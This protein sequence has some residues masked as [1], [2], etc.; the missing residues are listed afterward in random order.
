[1]INWILIMTCLNIASYNC[2]GHAPDR[3]RYVKHLC[4]HNDFVMIQEHWYMEDQIQPELC[5]CINDVMVHGCSGMNS[6]AMLEGRPYGGCAILWK[7]SINIKIKHVEVESKRICAI[8]ISLPDRDVL[9]INTYMPCDSPVNEIAYQETM[10]QIE[11][12]CTMSNVDHIVIGGDFNTDLSRPHSLNTIM[13]NE[14]VQRESLQYCISLNL[15]QVD[16]TYESKATRNKSL[17]DHFIVSNNLSSRVES[18]K[19]IH[20]G[21]NLSDHSPIILG[22]AIPVDYTNNKTPQ[23]CKSKSLW[24]RST[25]VDK[26]YYKC[27][28]DD[29]LTKLSIPIDALC[30]PVYGCSNV[31]HQEGIQQ[32][33]DD[34]C[35]CLVN[36]SVQAIHQSSTS[37]KSVPGW[38]AIVEEHRERAL[39]WHQLWKDNNSPRVGLIADIRQKTRAKYHYAIRLAKREKDKL[40]ADKVASALLENDKDFWKETNKIKHRLKAI[41]THIDSVNGMENIANLFADKQEALYQSVGYNEDDLRQLQTRIVCNVQ[42]KCNHDKCGFSHNINVAHVKKAIGALKPGK[43]DGSE[44]LTTD[45]FLNG[46]D[47]L[48]VLL[49]LLFN[50]MLHH[51]FSPAGTLMS[52]IIPIPKNSR[53]SL[54]D[55]SNYRGISLSSI[56]CKIID[57][58]ILDKYESV[59]KTSDYQFGFK[60]KHSTSQCTYVVQEVIQYYKNGGSNVNAMLLDASKAFDCVNYVKLFSLLLD[61]GLCPMVTN[62]LIISYVNQKARIKWQDCFSNTF[63]LMN[64]V[65]QGGILSPVLF[66]MY[67][68]ILLNQLQS[69]GLGCYIG[70]KFMGAFAYADDIILLAPTKQSMHG[71]LKLANLFSI[72]YDIKFNELKSKLIVFNACN[73][74]PDIESQIMCDGIAITSSANEVHL[75]NVIGPAASKEALSRGISDFYKKFNYMFSLFHHCNSTIKYRLFK[76]YCMS[77]YGSVLWDIS[78]NGVNRFYVAWRKCVRKLFKLPYRTHSYL[79]PYICQDFNIN[80]QIKK[81]ISNFIASI[82]RSDNACLLLCSKLTL[83]GSAST[84]SNNYVELQNAEYHLLEDPVNT[85]FGQLIREL[86]DWHMVLNMHERTEIIEWICLH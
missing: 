57:L 64:G 46:T 6:S 73:N 52:T 31:N 86:L 1:M 11:E 50:S 34:I 37:N 15:A 3:L 30:C 47:Q 48:Q 67:L 17:I 85:V 59:L 35:T 77:V 23:Q 82:N 45:H 32:F 12:V 14:F 53:K 10:I 40:A 27:C 70:H 18:Y 54:N 62:F 84:M 25:S 55:S 38:N 8:K 81:R 69:S 29:S 58:I 83:K 79:L 76:S 42:T 56:F 51:G 4:D 28:L 61:K 16:Y 78:S 71:M 60:K 5:T 49:S 80:D 9:L 39:F 22:L 68:D 66:T 24:H 2:H 75:G 7:K 20:E 13:L 43:S 74:K 36:A 19:V 26:D 33:H 65:K 41:P 21:D 44:G 72:D 63:R